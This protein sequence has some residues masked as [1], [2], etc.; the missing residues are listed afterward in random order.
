M[1]AY[2]GLALPALALAATLCGCSSTDDKKLNAPPEGF[3]YKDLLWGESFP[4]SV[5]DVK[6]QKFTY[7]EIML[8]E[9]EKPY[10]KYE[11]M[12]DNDLLA[13]K[14][15]SSYKLEDVENKLAKVFLTRVLVIDRGHSRVKLYYPELVPFKRDTTE[16]DDKTVSPHA[17]FAK[18]RLSRVK[19]LFDESF[20]ATKALPAIEAKYGKLELVDGQAHKQLGDLDVDF[21]T[22][23]IEGEKKVSCVLVVTDRKSMENYKLAVNNMCLGF[24]SEELIAKNLKIEETTAL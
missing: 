20:D 1:R 16:K 23:G 5:K 6:A 9:D 11:R 3:A 24:L 10:F 21:Y 19:Y 13:W 2:L 17:E 7:D 14:L 15:G 22:E 12:V 8:R 18:T 4:E